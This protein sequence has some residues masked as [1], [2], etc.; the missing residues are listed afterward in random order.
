MMRVAIAG[1]CGLARLIAHYID[2][3]TSHHVVFLSR[4]V[5]MFATQPDDMYNRTD[6]LLVV[7]IHDAH[8]GLSCGVHRLTFLTTAT[9]TTYL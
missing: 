3:D 9:A 5:R 4:N 8:L 1:T 6:T 7:R 2:E